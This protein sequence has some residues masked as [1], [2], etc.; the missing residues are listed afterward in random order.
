MKN[1][2]LLVLLFLLSAKLTAQITVTEATF[3]QLGDTLLIATD[4]L[5]ENIEVHRSGE[6]RRWSFINAKAPYARR[7]PVRIPT[8]PIPGFDADVLE[9][10]TGPDASIYFKNTKS[11]MEQVGYRGAT[12]IETGV[13]TTGYYHPALPLRVAPLQYGDE[14]TVSTTLYV[15]FAA[16]D[17]SAQFLFQLPLRPDSLRFRVAI[18]RTDKADD[19]GTLILPGAVYDVLREKRVENHRIF[20]DA[21]IGGAGWQDITKLAQH[22]KGMQPSQHISYY[23]FNDQTKE[24]IAVV[25]T[26]RDGRTPVQVQFKATEKAYTILS[27]ST[28]NSTVYAFPYETTGSAR[29]EFSNLPRGNY[30]LRIHNL[31]GVRVLEKRFAI[32]GYLT[33]QISLTTLRSG[34]YL[35]SLINDD[36]RVLTTKRLQVKRP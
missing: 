3:P 11:A 24:P 4:N 34:V 25:T 15:P 21:K 16:N 23:F 9:L 14:S 31:L 1:Y 22:V 13:I 28:A 6:G 18:E 10:Q 17:A 32:D 12:P 29:F 36:G 7:L 33:E 2:V 19:W 35:Y 8:Q 26:A 20:L 27:A 30:T 5:P